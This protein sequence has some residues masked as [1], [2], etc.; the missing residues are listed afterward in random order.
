MPVRTGPDFTITG[1]RQVL[2]EDR[3][4]SR[5]Y[6]VAA[7][8]QR[9]LMVQAPEDREAERSLD[10]VKLIFNFLTELERLVPTR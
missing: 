9:F 8:G 3:A 6:D 10:R 4:L 7:D 5:G 1:E 2:F